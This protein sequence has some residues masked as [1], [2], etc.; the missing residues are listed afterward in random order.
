MYYSIS[1]TNAQYY[2]NDVNL[3]DHHSLL[4]SKNIS[5][6][7]DGVEKTKCVAIKVYDYYK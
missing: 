1:L 2:I 5:V 4:L 3:F 7:T 6:S